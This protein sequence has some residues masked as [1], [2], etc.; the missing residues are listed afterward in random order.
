MGSLLIVALV[1]MLMPILIGGIDGYEKNRQEMMTEMR[2]EHRRRMEESA[3]RRAEMKRLKEEE[4]TKASQ[5]N[6][7]TNPR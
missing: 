1:A 6:K 7:P 5:Q 2:A 3:L 4:A